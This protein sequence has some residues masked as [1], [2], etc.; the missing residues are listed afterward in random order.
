LRSRSLIGLVLWT[1]SAAFAPAAASSKLAKAIFA[2]GCFWSEE[3][4][5]E[6][7]PGVVSVTSGYTGGQVKSPTYEQVSSGVTGHAEAVEVL[8]DP[9]KTSYAQLLE[10][11]WHN[12]DPMDAGGQFC[13]HGPQYRSGIFYLDDAQK[14]AAEESKRQLEAN[15][16]FA[17]KIV[18]QILP[19]GPFFPAEAYHQ[20]FA[21]KNAVRYGAYKMGCRRDARLT[22]I[23]GDAAGSHN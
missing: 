18:T 7:R 4:A 23:W 12:V 15:P 17:G 11:F 10:V 3:K 8:F 14:A 5:F 1:V 6:G 20:D 21:K 2:G 16:K 9:G 13:D 22:Q 19:A